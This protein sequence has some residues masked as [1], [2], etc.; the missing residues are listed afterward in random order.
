[1]KVVELLTI[2]GKMLQILHEN[3]IKIDD[4]QYLELYNDYKE[5]ERECLKVT[6]IVSELSSR[7]NICERKVYKIIRQMSRHCQIRAV[8]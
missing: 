8:R 1:M 6:Y 2:C 7:Y 4:Y 3:G 5:M